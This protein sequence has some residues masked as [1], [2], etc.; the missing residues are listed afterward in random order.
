M[1]KKVTIQDIADALGISRNT[2]SKAINNTDGIAEVTREKVLQKAIEMGYK[3]FSYVSSL[4]N[5]GHREEAAAKTE[6]LG[7]IAVFSTSYISNSH[8]ASPMLD[9]IHQE[10]STMGY[11]LT[12]HRIRRSAFQTGELPS[13][14]FLE[15][16]KAIVCVE[17]FDAS[18]CDML[19]DL[20]LPILFIDGPAR[21]GEHSVNADLLMMENFSE[22]THFIH[23]M[24]DRGFRK[25]GFI[26]DYNH[27]QSFWE[28]Y[29]AFRAA[30][31]IADI[32]VR[33]E[34][35]IHTKDQDLEA[36]ANELDSLG[37]LPEVF[38]CANDFVA[39]DA[40]KLLEMKS[41]E[42]LHNVHFLGFDDS[43]ESRFFYP[44]LST[45]HIHSQAMAFSALH[46]LLTRIEEPTMEYRT[47]YVASDLVLRET[48]EF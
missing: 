44:A 43:H 10:L 42:I 15:R 47:I 14:F 38:I 22:I 23:I 28:R 21:R 20:G 46:L 26:G 9:K 19:C 18:Y 45:V 8:F 41:S 7:E 12:F 40:M 39:I 2:V 3:Q 25:I 27:C 33:P 36:L 4:S 16:V 48:T 32:P 30:M 17:V 31:A 13:T 5:I 29:C 11:T 1:N 35:V 37:E 34:F 24:L 6:L